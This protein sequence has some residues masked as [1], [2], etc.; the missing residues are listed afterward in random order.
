MI[1][2]R[3]RVA[4]V[5]IALSAW[6]CDASE[7]IVPLAGKWRAVLESPGGE[8]P[9]T[10][11]VETAGTSVDAWITNGAERIR[12]GPSRLDGANLEIDLPPYRSR[13]VAT[14]SDGGARLAGKWQRH[15]GA[16]WVTELPILA[17]RSDAPRFAAPTDEPD[18]AVLDGI[19]GRWRVD[20]SSS[21]DYAVGEFSVA[22]NGLAIGT[23]LTTVGDYRYLAGRVRERTLHLSCFDGAHA[24]LFRADLVQNGTL[25]G[26]FWSRGSW[27]ETWTARKDADVELPDAFGLTRWTGSVALGELSYPDVDGKQR[28]LD[29]PAFAGRARLFVVFGTWCPNCSDLT[30]LLVELHGRYRDEGLSIVGLAFEFGDDAE[31]RR[32]A[33][34]AYMA[35]KSATWPVL[36][37]GPTDKKRAGEA[38]PLIDRVLSYPTTI[39]MDR[40][41]RVDS[42]YTGFSG[43]ATGPRH[44]ELEGRFESIVQRLLRD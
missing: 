44:E 5:A 6:G 29:D 30:D 2:D 35:H 28:R 7:P 43:P 33:V 40:G 17:L 32:N 37:A 27:H 1:A 25:R 16:G 23:F 8:L 10:L 22:S 9:F 12:V 4:L 24:F 15:K 19:A 42:I 3:F 26:D 14:V 38:F 39:F 34:R 11:L 20:F 31:E 13:I 41:G 18:A 21:D 36:I